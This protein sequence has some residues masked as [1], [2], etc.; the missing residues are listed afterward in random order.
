MLF[1]SD[2]Q[3]SCC[4]QTDKLKKEDIL[5]EPYA[6]KSQPINVKRKVG[7]NNIFIKCSKFQSTEG[8]Y[9]VLKSDGCLNIC[10]D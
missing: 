10:V 5:K 1:S 6:F 9:L 2:C 4:L 8:F 7:V 3:C